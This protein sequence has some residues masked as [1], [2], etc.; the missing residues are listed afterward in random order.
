MKKSEIK[1]LLKKLTIKEKASLLSGLDAWNTKPIKR[2]NIPSISMAD[3][4][5]GLRKQYSGDDLGIE[6]SHP[7]TCFPTASLLAC[8]WDKELAEKQG[9]ALGEEAADQGLQ[10]ILGPGNNIKRTPLCGRNFEYFS[11]DPF[12]SGNMAS[13]IIKGIQSK[14]IGTALKHFAAN[15][16]ETDRLVLDEIISERALRE[17]Y[18]AS[19]EIPVKEAKPTT[20]M[21]AYNKVNGHYCSQNKWLLTDVLRKDWGFKGVVMSDWGAVDNRPQGVY[22]GLDLEMPSSNCINDKEIVKAYKGKRVS[23]PSSDSRFDN[24]LTEKQ[25]DACAERMLRL[26][27]SLD[28]KKAAKKCDYEA[29][30]KLAEKIARE[31]MV[32]LKNDGILPLKENAD[33]AVI[34]EMAVNPRYQGSGSS[35]VNSFRTDLPLD[36]LKKF[37]SVSYAKGYSL[38]NGGDTSEIENAVNVA[39]GKDAVVILTGLPDNYES[40]GFDRS[41]L[42]IPESHVELIKRIYKV[43][44]NVV[45]VLCNGAPITMPFLENAS[46][47][48]EA[49]LSGEAGAGAIA[50]ILFGK[51]CPCGKLAE[52]F[53]N[54]IE[55]TPAYLNFPGNGRTVRFGED[56]FVGYRYYEKRGVPVLFPFGYGLSYTN[57]KYSGL[58]LSASEIGENDGLTVSVTVKNTGDFDGK[59]I[60]QLYVGE[61]SPK[62]ARPVKELKGFKKVELKKG[63]E[64][65]VE[66]TLD[67][68][69]FAYWDERLGKWNVN[70][71][72]FG[73]FIGAA[74]SDIRAV[75]EVT[76]HAEQTLEKL[77]IYS[78]LRDL[79]MHPNG[80]AAVSR[81]LE[82]MG[83]KES[84][85]FS[86]SEKDALTSLDW[87]PLRNVITMYGM[88]M[89]IDDLEKLLEKVNG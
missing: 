34:G 32:L 73:I 75:G 20:L 65:T 60:V 67:R 58:T 86:D 43:N 83:K 68:R 26:V 1:Q 7:A 25:I 49:Y 38:E 85:I 13:G 35:R 59:E 21:C 9:A 50:E 23:I 5:H 53:P 41:T 62:V 46:A 72:N 39:E 52:T 64:K 37:A 11:E 27:Y 18:L 87:C 2:L 29:H 78:Y 66:F 30:H 40:E 48:L 19:Y 55:D 80:K 44:K 33:I 81:I 89:S 74:S 17:I 57:F 6:T 88:K 16:Q 14:G 4:P 10:I 22:A 79:R 61:N 15:S 71:G 8:S 45:V 82:L 84:E 54:R 42:D 77:T 76:V 31:C 24:T 36:E 51:A 12:L 3:G 69:A 28:E 56:I 47:V 63:E 70:S